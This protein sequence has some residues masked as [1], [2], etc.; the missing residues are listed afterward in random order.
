M[1][2]KEIDELLE[3]E[4][5]GENVNMKKIEFQQLNEYEKRQIEFE[6]MR[7]AAKS[8]Q[9]LQ[10]IKEASQKQEKKPNNLKTK[11]DLLKQQ[12]KI[13]RESIPVIQVKSPEKLALAKQREEERLKAEKYSKT[14]K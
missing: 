13:L 8:R 9:V 14:R 6:D 12:Q 10:Q 3:T 11:L 1:T 4:K 7:R 2:S 5:T